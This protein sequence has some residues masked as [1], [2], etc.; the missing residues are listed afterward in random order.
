MSAEEE[1]K[2]DF[3]WEARF[4][5]GVGTGDEDARGAWRGV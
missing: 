4:A 3:R 1:R 5:V 2:E